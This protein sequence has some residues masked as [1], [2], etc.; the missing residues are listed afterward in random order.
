VHNR[1]AGD[2]DVVTCSSDG[3]AS[4]HADPSDQTGGCRLDAFARSV[5]ALKTA[6]RHLGRSALRRS[7]KIR[8]SGLQV[9]RAGVVTA[10]LLA[11]RRNHL[12]TAATVSV[13]VRR[14]GRAPL[15]LRVS[16]SGHTLLDSP[17][18]I[19]LVVDYKPANGRQRKLSVTRTFR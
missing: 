9:P 7:S 6:L 3:L 2:P 14:S 13:V 10:K 5:P 8:L 12:G 1:S 18:A 16:R 17:S 15:V 19:R 4:L 11:T